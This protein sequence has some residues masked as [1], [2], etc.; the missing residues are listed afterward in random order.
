M[1]EVQAW[2]LWVRHLQDSL[3][4]VEGM[5]RGSTGE[6][7]GWFLWVGRMGSYWSDIIWGR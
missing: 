7:L 3:Y 5:G 1:V 2:T 6:L 4:L